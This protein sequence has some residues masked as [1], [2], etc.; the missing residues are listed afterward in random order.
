MRISGTKRTYAG[1]LKMF[2][3]LIPNNIIEDYL[4][5]S[6]KSR[7]IRDL[8]ASFT[9][10]AKKDINATNQSHARYPPPISETS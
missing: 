10:L 7:K 2:L 3:S 8:D 4:L 1:D 6:P 9:A 5:V